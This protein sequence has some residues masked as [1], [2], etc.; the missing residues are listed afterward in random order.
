LVAGVESSRIPGLR[1][2]RALLILTSN[3]AKT[4]LGDFRI[5]SL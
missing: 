3:Y 5:I 4:T 1:I 2:N